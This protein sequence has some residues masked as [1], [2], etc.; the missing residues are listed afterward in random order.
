MDSKERKEA[1]GG[2]VNQGKEI[3]MKTLEYNRTQGSD[4]FSRNGGRG[5]GFA[6]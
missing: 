6:K 5:N 3:D 2:V 1:D 4:G